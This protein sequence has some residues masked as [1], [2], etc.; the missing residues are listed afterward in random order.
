MAC[1]VGR[2]FRGELSGGIPAGYFLFRSFT[3]HGQ[4]PAVSG[5]RSSLFTA[6]VAD[7]AVEEGGIKGSTRLTKHH[8]FNIWL[9]AWDQLG[10]GCNEYG[11]GGSSSGVLLLDLSCSGICDPQ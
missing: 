11:G 7:C 10:G 1:C 2:G 5:N 6:P 4:P 9:Q 3:E 8:L